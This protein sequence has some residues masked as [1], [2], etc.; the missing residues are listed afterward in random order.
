VANAW[1]AEHRIG[2]GVGLALGLELGLSLFSIP[3]ICH[4]QYSGIRH[5][6]PYLVQIGCPSSIVP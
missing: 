6:G 3:G 5:S 1:N 2:L 4:I